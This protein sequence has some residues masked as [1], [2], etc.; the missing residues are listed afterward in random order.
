MSD[1]H[2]LE[3]LETKIDAVNERLNEIVRLDE[4]IYAIVKRLDRFEERIDKQEKD[5]NTIKGI[6]GYNQQAVRNYERFVWI[7][8]SA[9][10]TSVTYF[11]K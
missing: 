6:V 4:K 9:L 3:R 11:I 7:L 1:E 2:R 8:I 10:A 5:I